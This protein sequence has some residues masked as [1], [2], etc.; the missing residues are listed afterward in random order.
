MPELS[1][2]ES[3]SSSDPLVLSD[4]KMLF[5]DLESDFGNGVDVAVGLDASAFT[6]TLLLLFVATDDFDD[7]GLVLM[8]PLPALLR[9]AF[10]KP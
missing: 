3:S 9:L 2:S 4:E 1:S 5:F 6:D 10:A 8:L 7:G